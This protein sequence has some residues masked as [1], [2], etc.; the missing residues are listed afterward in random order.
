MRT[1]GR[2]HGIVD[3]DHFLPS[4][5]VREICRDA[6][7]AVDAL[8]GWRVVAIG[9][10]DLLEIVAIWKLCGVRAHD[11]QEGLRQGEQFETA[12]SAN[13]EATAKALCAD[14]DLDPDQTVTHAY[15]DDF[16]AQEWEYWWTSN[17][18]ISGKLVIGLMWRLY[19]ARAVVELSRL[20]KVVKYS[21]KV[22][23]YRRRHG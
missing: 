18:A 12:P 15:G 8:I 22:V 20:K 16:T 3:V 9:T 14:D 6:K 21:G 13:I 17:M 1:S 23:P 5:I 2:G 7:A 11:E 19:R 4:P 10:L